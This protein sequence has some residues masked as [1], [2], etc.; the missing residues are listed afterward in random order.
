[1]LNAPAISTAIAT[2]ERETVVLH[3]ARC[4]KSLYQFYKVQR[5]E[6]EK[7]KLILYMDVLVPEDYQEG[8]VPE[9]KNLLNS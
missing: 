7:A 5:M 3:Y 4:I 8:E 6:D 9:L 1:M 2:V